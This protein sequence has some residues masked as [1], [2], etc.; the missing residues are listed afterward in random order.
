MAAPLYLLDTGILVLLIRGGPLG[1]YI[2]TRYQLR[3]QPIKPLI[4]A[5]SKGEI[6]SIA[7]RAKTPWSAAK[8]QT[9]A[10]L[11]NEVV[12][13]EIDQPAIMAA[14]EDIE[15]FSVKQPGGG[16]TMGKNDLWIAAT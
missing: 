11:L 6:R 9:L 16:L 15:Y 13:V 12:S 7:R 3:H 4:S 14:Y 8:R 2:D 5:V 1:Q 10:D